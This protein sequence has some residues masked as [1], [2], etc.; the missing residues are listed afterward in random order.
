MSKK[1]DVSIAQEYEE[2]GET[3]TRWVN[4][5]IAFEKEGKPPRI[6]LNALPIPDKN[7]EIWINLFEQKPKDQGGQGGGNSYAQAK[8]GGGGNPW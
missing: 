6:K 5:G 4:L 3:K 7:G 1:Y 8:D 2:N